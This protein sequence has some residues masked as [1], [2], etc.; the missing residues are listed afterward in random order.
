MW[1]PRLGLS[2]PRN[3]EKSVVLTSAPTPPA[4]VF[5]YRTDGDLVCACLRVRNRTAPSPYTAV[6]QGPQYASRLL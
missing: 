3:R 4:Y 2:V 6:G 1:A 5:C